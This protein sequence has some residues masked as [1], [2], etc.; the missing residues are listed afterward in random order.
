MTY[1]YDELLNRARSQ[2]PKEVFEEKRYDIPDPRIITVGK[3][4]IIRNFSDIA[5][6]LNRDPDHV[7]KYLTRELATAADV[8][9]GRA[10]FNGKFRDSKIMN[11]M[12]AY[13]KEYVF[14]HECG[15]PDTR[16]VKEGRVNLLKCEACGA[17][18]SIRSI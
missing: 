8:K 13:A 12:E 11:R 14:C 6:A 1:N 7:M 17:R 3:K 4:T 18:S 5:N 15:K 9:G 16:L 2:L 10:I